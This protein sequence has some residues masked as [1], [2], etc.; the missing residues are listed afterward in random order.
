MFF[1]TY[2]DAPTDPDYFGLLNA[3][4]SEK[5]AWTALAAALS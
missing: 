1:Y 5:P 2:E 4:G 3:D